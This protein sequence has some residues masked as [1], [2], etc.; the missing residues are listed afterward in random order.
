[1]GDSSKV[2]RTV[3]DRERWESTLDQLTEEHEGEEITIELLDL[4]YGDL[5]EAERMP[6]AYVTY[7]RRDD[8]VIIAVG[9]RSA[10]YP[11][12]LRHMIERPTEVRVDARPASAALMVVDVDGTATLV[13]FFGVAGSAG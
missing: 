6:F 8:T 3:V 2:D 4:P 13:S 5:R 1:M 11:V 7:D 9:G 10:R 12:V